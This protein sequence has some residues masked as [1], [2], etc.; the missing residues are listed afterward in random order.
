MENKP[1]LSTV[2]EKDNLIVYLSIILI[3]IIT[4]K[5]HLNLIFTGPLAHDGHVRCVCKK[6]NLR[7]DKPMDTRRKYHTQMADTQRTHGGR[8]P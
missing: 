2:L 6:L 4:L 1:N 8:T 5:V 7:E 3:I